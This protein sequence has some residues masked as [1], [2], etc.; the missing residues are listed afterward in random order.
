MNGPGQE[1]SPLPFG[2]TLT[3]ARYKAI[4]RAMLPWWA[5]PWCLAAVFIYLF[6]FMGK[7]WSRL[8]VDLADTIA[9]LIVALVL[10]AFVYA[11]TSVVHRRNWRRM[12]GLHGAL[13]GHVDGDGIEWR[14]AI[15]TARFPWTR[16]SKA[17]MRDDMML[18]TYAPRCALYFPREFFAGGAQW[19]DFKA[20]VASR[21]AGAPR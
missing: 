6:V 2:G 7:D 9:N 16:I 5:R 8:L 15:S 14:T 1:G 12:T 13:S 10:L 11:L 21:V 18:L 20:M 19:S 4:Q 17:Q 3:L